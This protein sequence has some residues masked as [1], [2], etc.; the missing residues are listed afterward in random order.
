MGTGIIYK[1]VFKLNLRTGV[2]LCKTKDDNI[3]KIKIL[4]VKEQRIA[5]HIW[6][7][8][9]SS[10]SS[11]EKKNVSRAKV[12]IRLYVNWS[13]IYLQKNSIIK[14]RNKKKKHFSYKKFTLT[15]YRKTNL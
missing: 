5:K 13:S 8:E 14:S 15:H 4:N 12:T 2:K 9:S 1:Q 7:F 11:A 10:K 6:S 3:Q